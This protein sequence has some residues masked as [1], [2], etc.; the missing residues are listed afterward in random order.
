MKILLH[1]GQSKTGTSAIQ[2]FLT[3]NRDRLR[4]HRILY[5]ATRVKG[6]T[7]NLGAHNA[8]ADSLL[9]KIQFPYL[10]ADEYFHQFIDDANKINADLLILSAE[11]FFGGE[12]RI[13]DV[14]DE[15]EYFELYR[16]KIEILASYL[17][18]YDISILAYLRPQVDWIASAVSQ[19]V[20]IERLISQRRIYQTDRQFFQ[21][22]RP[23]LK[24]AD[25]LDVWQEGIKPSSFTVIPYLRNKLH[26]QSSVADFLKRTGLENINFEYADSNLQ[27]NTSL[28]REFIEVKKILNKTIRSKNEERAIIRCMEN[29]S[30][31][32]PQ[33]CEYALDPDVKREI[34]NFSSEQ[35]TRI[36]QRF[37]SDGHLFVAASGKKTPTPLGDKEVRH[38]L[39]IFTAEFNRPKYKILEWSFFLR[40]SLRD[41]ARPVQAA[42]HQLKAQYWS[43]KYKH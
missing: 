39:R 23:L 11:H 12:P 24:Y 15:V 8:V 19:T 36:S 34:E 40:A 28:N 16:K 2:A 27:V 22:M 25:L 30:H 42:L 33:D 38:A 10:S 7:L 20:R 6:M 3:L 21:L 37:M 35:N 18:G 32:N 43:W 4:E 41:K 1:I 5:P 13:W 9:G 29:L 14:R 31:S 17:T 26:E